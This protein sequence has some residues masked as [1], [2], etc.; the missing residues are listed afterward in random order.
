[1]PPP[2]SHLSVF[3]NSFGNV[4]PIGEKVTY[5]CQSGFHW[6]SPGL[7]LF[8]VGCNIN[9]IWDSHIN[10]PKCIP[11]EELAPNTTRSCSKPE[12]PA[13]GVDIE[14]FPNS[15]GHFVFGT[16]VEY[17][18]AFPF[19]LD[20]TVINLPYRIQCLSSGHWSSSWV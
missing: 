14:Y 10:W 20:A 2:E 13:E 18:C 7:N 11:S 4:V 3:A 6:D 17:S 9:A 12:M 1:M 8:T 16:Y 15:D 19:V 5:G